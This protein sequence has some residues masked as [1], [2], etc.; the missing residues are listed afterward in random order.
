MTRVKILMS[1]RSWLNRQKNLGTLP[2]LRSTIINDRKLRLSFLVQLS[3]ININIHKIPHSEEAC[4]LSKAGPKV[5]DCVG[6]LSIAHL[7]QRLVDCAHEMTPEPVACAI[8]QYNCVLRICENRPL[9]NDCF[10]A[11]P[12]FNVQ[13]AY[14]RF[15]ASRADAVRAADEV[16][17]LQTQIRK[18][19]N[20]QDLIVLT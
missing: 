16:A 9:F 6:L 7:V 10:G 14:D 17:N 13:T 2:T 1:I 5:S 20:I 12:I 15:K 8:D 4:T 19:C 11:I 18:M 3:T